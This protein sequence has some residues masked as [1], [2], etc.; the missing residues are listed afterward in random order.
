V[1]SIAH[2]DPAGE[3]TAVLA[4]LGGSVQVASVAGR[5]TVE[6]GDFFLGPLESALRPG[7]MALEVRFP[8][9]PPRSGSAFV[10]LARRHGD[11]AM[12]GVGA[13]VVLDERGAVVAA[14][15]AYVSMGP[16]PEVH[17][18]TAEAPA[19]DLAE[20]ASWRA[21]A[22]RA[23]ALLDPEADIHASADYRRHLGRV[24]TAR[25]LA[26]AADRAG[27]AVQR[28]ERPERPERIEEPLSA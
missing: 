22:A 10:E 28:P 25:A 2:A 11:Y 12:C 6:A 26:Q 13:Q 19:R 23:T 20:A 15:T 9:A 16:V 17:D 1:G 21:A 7:E 18:L 14:R 8:A 24:L 3:M 4:L 5:R 27:A